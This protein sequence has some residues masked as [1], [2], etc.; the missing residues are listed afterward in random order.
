MLLVAIVELGLFEPHKTSAQSLFCVLRLR[1]EDVK[2]PLIEEALP[3]VAIVGEREV[4]GS[5]CS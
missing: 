2:G 1:P 5:R 3:P 4:M